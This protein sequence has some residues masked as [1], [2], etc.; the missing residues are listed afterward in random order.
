V[1]VRKAGPG[2][3]AG[4]ETGP[5]L[6]EPV[7]SSSAYS[8]VPYIAPELLMLVVTNT[9]PPAMMG[10]EIRPLSVVDHVAVGGRVGPEEPIVARPACA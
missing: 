6:I 8:E 10:Y 7:V 5:H 3:V 9:R 1:I 4:S 2:V